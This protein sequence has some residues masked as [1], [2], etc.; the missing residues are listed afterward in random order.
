MRRSTAKI[1]TLLVVLAMIVA[2]LVCEITG[3]HGAALWI[4][5]VG[6]MILAVLSLFLRCPSC[7][8]LPRRGGLFDEYC[9]H[10]GEWLDVE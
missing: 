3:S 8:H 4:V 1:L 5:L 6:M 2:L 9:S 10:C 7:G